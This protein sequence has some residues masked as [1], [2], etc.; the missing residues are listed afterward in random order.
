MISACQ[1]CHALRFH[2]EC[3]KCCHKGKVALPALSQ[4]PPGLQA[5]FND[6]SAE[7]KNF[8]TNIR[9]YNSAF[10]FASFGAQTY[11]PLVMAPTVSV[12]M[13]RHTIALE[14]FTLL[15]ASYISSKGTKLL[16]HGV[17]APQNTACRHDMMQTVVI[18]E[19]NP[20]AAAYRNM[21]AVQQEEDHHATAEGRQPQEVR[22]QFKRGPDRR[23]YNQLTHD[24]VA[25]VFVGEDGAPPA[26]RDIIV[27]PRNRPPQRISYMSCHIDPDPGWHCGMQHIAERQTARRTRLTMQQFYNYCLAVREEFSPIHSAGKLFQ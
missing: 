3:E 7:G 10:S 1:Y 21:H 18:T 25:A 20:Y 19:N 14:L 24:E 27:Y 4:Y 22:M 16:T 11:T 6:D 17:N 5:L 15:R 8:R 2:G 13:V 23:Q 12:F 26:Y 9:N